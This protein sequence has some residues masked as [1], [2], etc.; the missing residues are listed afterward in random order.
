MRLFIPNRGSKLR[1]TDNWLFTLRAKYEN[2]SLFK[3]LGLEEVGYNG[4]RLVVIGP[5]DPDFNTHRSWNRDGDRVKLVRAEDVQVVIPAGTTL[6]IVTVNVHYT[7]KR[8]D[9]VKFQIGKVLKR[10]RHL[11]PDPRFGGTKFVA[12]LED[13]NRIE[14]ELVGPAA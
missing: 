5:D 4:N 7:L 10:D 11:L 3:A 12:S 9:S 6:S 1:L 14:F 2:K 13:V 8:E